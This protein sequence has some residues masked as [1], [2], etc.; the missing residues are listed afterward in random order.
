MVPRDIKVLVVETRVPKG[1]R[2]G[3]VPLKLVSR[4]TRVYLVLVVL[5]DSRAN[6][7]LVPRD[8]RE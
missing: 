3:K 7:K 4:D 1:H 6:Q 5:R 8:I 2:V